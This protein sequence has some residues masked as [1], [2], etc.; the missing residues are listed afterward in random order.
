MVLA[1]LVLATLAILDDLKAGLEAS[2][3]ER[4]GIKTI[5]PRFKSGRY[6]QIPFD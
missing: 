5:H 6:L 4:D 1:S 3:Y 2:E